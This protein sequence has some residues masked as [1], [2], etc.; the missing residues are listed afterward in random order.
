VLAVLLNPALRAERDRRALSGAQL[1]DAGL[2]PNP[3]L[4]YSLDV[5]TGDASGKTT[6]FGLG[7][8]WPIDALFS[9][10]ARID[11]AKRH[12]QAVELDIAW[13]DLNNAKTK[14]VDLEGRL[15][16]A[17]VALE[18]ASAFYRIP[19]AE[20]VTCRTAEASGKENNP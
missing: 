15:A 13:N 3:E 14:V 6:A 11:T 5:P 7:L 9:R 2:L 18:L 10:S 1:L 17:V 16:R 19:K 20:L 12:K 8:S 4:T